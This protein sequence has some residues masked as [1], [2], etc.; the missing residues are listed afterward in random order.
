MYVYRRPVGMV[1]NLRATGEKWVSILGKN[2]CHS[3]RSPKLLAATSTLILRVRIWALPS[4]QCQAY[5][6]L[7]LHFP[8]IYLLT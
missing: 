7:Q 8:S 4:I 1:T 6:C 2:I 5:E 3:L